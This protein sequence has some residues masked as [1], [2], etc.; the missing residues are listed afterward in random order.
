[1]KK[2]ERAGCNKPFIPT[3]NPVK[4]LS[5]AAQTPLNVPG[6]GSSSNDYF[7]AFFFFFR[8]ITN[9]IYLCAGSHLDAVKHVVTAGF[10]L[11]A[12]I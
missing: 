8:I 3:K 11:R 12:V 5:T 10:P 2:L 9:N 6:L 1:M 4:I 7:L